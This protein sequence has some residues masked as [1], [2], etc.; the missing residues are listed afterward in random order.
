MEEKIEYY[1]KE[2]ISFKDGNSVG[3]D[4]TIKIISPILS[5]GWIKVETSGEHDMKRVFW[6]KEDDLIEKVKQTEQK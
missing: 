3:T 2:E 1:L 6:V 4:I 5:E